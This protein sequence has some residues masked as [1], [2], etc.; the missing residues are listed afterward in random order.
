MHGTYAINKLPYQLPY[1]HDVHVYGFDGGHPGTA[2]APRA[3]RN[4]PLLVGLA[5][6]GHA[7]KMLAACERHYNFTF[8]GI[9]QK[10]DHVWRLASTF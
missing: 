4:M 6:C 2:Y 3:L 5:K 1:S 8:L 7:A 10:L 9:P